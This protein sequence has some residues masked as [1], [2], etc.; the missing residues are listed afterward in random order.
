MSSIW[1]I[2][3]LPCCGPV[4]YLAVMPAIKQPA[5]ARRQLSSAPSAKDNGAAGNGAA[6]AGGADIPLGEYVARRNAVLKG[7]KG[8]AGVVLAGEGAPPLLG[9]WRPDFN[10]FYLTGLLNEPGAAVLFDPT[11]ENPDRRCVLIL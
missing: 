3:I 7:L 2:A 5:R 1:V 11:H 6:A 10:F 8:A 9:R 4:V